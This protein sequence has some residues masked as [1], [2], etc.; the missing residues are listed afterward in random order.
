MKTIHLFATFTG[1]KYITVNLN[2]LKAA[3][4]DEI[5]SSINSV[6]PGGS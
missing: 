2:Q 3:T 5:I 6:S 4:G 1:F